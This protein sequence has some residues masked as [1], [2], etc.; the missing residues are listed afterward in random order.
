MVSAHAAELPRDG[1]LGVNDELTK[2]LINMTGEHRERV[3]A[4]TPTD[5]TFHEPDANLFTDEDLSL[6]AKVRCDNLE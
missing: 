3:K 6:H 1:M 5:F 2:L 4:S